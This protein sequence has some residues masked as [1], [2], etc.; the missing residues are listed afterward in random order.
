MNKINLKRVLLGGVVAGIVF[1][2]L[3]FAS[4]FLYLGDEWKGVMEDLG[5]PIDETAGMYIYSIIACFVVGILAVWLYAA[6]RP[7]FGAGPKTAFL[8]GFVFWILSGLFAYI[9]FGTTGMFP[10]NLLIIDCLIYLVTVIVATLLGAWVY[11]EETH[12]GG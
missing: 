5:Y 2:V 3:G 10:I 12:Q 11:R 6:I 1:L 4:Y 8:A 7:R 9:S